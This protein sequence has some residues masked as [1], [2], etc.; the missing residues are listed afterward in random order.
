MSED[1]WSGPD[2]DAVVSY[3]ILWDETAPGEEIELEDGRTEPA[4]D[5]PV[6]YWDIKDDPRSENH[7]SLCVQV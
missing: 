1:L 7:A 3:V 5:G 2:E 4:Y 6:A